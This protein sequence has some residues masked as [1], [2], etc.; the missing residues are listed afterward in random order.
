MDSKHNSNLINFKCHAAIRNFS[1]VKCVIGDITS[2][3]LAAINPN[4]VGSRCTQFFLRILTLLEDDFIWPY[5]LESED[6]M[7]TSSFVSDTIWSETY[8]SVLYK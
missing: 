8:L 5:S 2:K 6:R 3:L 1:F 7:S 4:R